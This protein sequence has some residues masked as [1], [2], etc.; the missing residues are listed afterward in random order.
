MKDKFL[1]RPES[2]PQQNLLLQNRNYSSEGEAAATSLPTPRSSRFASYAK[3]SKMPGIE[4]A[5]SPNHG[6]G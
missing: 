6:D 2:S 5:P 3:A 4:N 1:Y